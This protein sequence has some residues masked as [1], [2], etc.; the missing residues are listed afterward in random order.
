[1]DIAPR[2][3][4]RRWA[5]LLP[6]TVA[7]GLALGGCAE[8]PGEVEPLGDAAIATVAPVEGGELPSV[9]LSDVAAQRLG[10]ATDVVR[11]T[12]VDGQPRTVIPYAAVV[13][14]PEGAAFAYTVQGP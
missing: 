9:T 1:M 4:R 10:I 6:V 14:D 7:A 3:H 11:D 2:A 5:A 12:A 8:P 13:Y